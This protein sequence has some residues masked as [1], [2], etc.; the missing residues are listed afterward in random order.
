MNC[1]GT[2]EP[3]IG[4]SVPNVSPTARNNTISNP[5]TTTI[6]I[7]T[8]RNGDPAESGP[9]A[10]QLRSRPQEAGGL[11]KIRLK[12]E[13]RGVTSRPQIARLGLPRNAP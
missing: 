8:S 2:V 1:K 11:I 4:N 10:S 7:G 13:E 5:V 9:C 3:S 12:N 6:Q